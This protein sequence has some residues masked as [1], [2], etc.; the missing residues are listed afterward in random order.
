MRVEFFRVTTVS[1]NMQDVNES[2]HSNPSKPDSD[3][4]NHNMALPT[5]NEG[6]ATPVADSRFNPSMD[7]KQNLHETPMNAHSLETLALL[8]TTLAR[9]LPP[10]VMPRLTEKVLMR[11][12]L[13]E[14]NSI[15]HEAGWM[16][17]GCFM[18][19]FESRCRASIGESFIGHPDISR[20]ISLWFG[21]GLPWSQIQLDLINSFA[22]PRSIQDAYSKSVAAL[23]FG[24]AFPLLCRDLYVMYYSVFEAHPHRLINFVESVCAKLPSGMKDKVVTRLAR[25]ATDEFW[26]MARP[27]WHSTDSSVISLIEELIRV[28]ASVREFN[29]PPNKPRVQLTSDKVNKVADADNKRNGGSPTPWLMEWVSKHKSVWVVNPIENDGAFETK[30]GVL[31]EKTEVKGPLWRKGRPYYLV[32]FPNE[33]RARESLTAVLPPECFRPFQFPKNT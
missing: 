29:P 25:E 20:Q 33:Q 24:S 4:K 14:V 26:Q 15:L 12:H 23:T 28:D 18:R 32:G 16:I 30:M 5:G 27:F 21:R 1:I 13:E 6:F 7:S 17:E 22:S 8:Q 3:T 10:P 19:G 9:L 11:T 2:S 31:K